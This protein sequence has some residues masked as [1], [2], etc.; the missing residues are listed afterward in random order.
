MVMIS[1]SNE[2]VALAQKARAFIFVRRAVMGATILEL[3][4]T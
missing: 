4:V 1:A 2:A 3:F